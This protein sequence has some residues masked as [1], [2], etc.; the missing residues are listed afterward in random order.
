MDGSAITA[1]VSLLPV[2]YKESSPPPTTRHYPHPADW[3]TSEDLPEKLF[4]AEEAE[5]I[6]PNFFLILMS[7][8][9]ATTKI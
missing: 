6:E 1:A 9:I 8:A 2:G 3:Y 5:K 4:K 7:V